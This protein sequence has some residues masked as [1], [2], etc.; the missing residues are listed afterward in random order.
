MEE[1]QVTTKKRA[2]PS[3]PSG[4]QIV[5]N[6]FV[7]SYTLQALPVAIVPK[8]L[9]RKHAFSNI[10]CAVSFIHAQ[11]PPEQA[12][13][14]LQKL[15]KEYNQP[16]EGLV[17]AP[18]RSNLQPFGTL[19]YETWL[20]PDLQLWEEHTIT[21]GTTVDDFRK[22]L[23]AP[24]RIKT[25]P[26]VTTLERG[27]YML[28]TTG[29]ISGGAEA[30]AD[31]PKPPTL[32]DLKFVQQLLTHVKADDGRRLTAVQCTGGLL[33]A[34]YEGS[35]APANANATRLAGVPIEGPAVFFCTRK[36]KL[37]QNE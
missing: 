12:Q 22:G 34:A 6:L 1:G 15:A 31:P 7:C 24:K 33:L 9:N 20:G 36:T 30:P 17:P 32:P 21:H 2:R 35:A 13:K 8:T 23:D 3:K 18:D 26:G 27:V 4:P 14:L 19:P 11:N 25:T 10:P 5:G 37:A 28:R 29:K 16:I